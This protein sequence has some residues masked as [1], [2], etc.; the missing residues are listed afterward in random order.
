MEQLLRKLLRTY[1]SICGDVAKP[2]EVIWL[3]MLPPLVL[4]LALLL[5]R[6]VGLVAACSIQRKRDRE[7]EEKRGK[8]TR[9]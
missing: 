7:R 2:L 8:K 1:E 5:D 6:K 9:E 3:R 4:L